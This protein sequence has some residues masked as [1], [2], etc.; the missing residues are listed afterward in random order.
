MKTV[1]FLKNPSLLVPVAIILTGLCLGL[2]IARAQTCNKIKMGDNI[3]ACW[4]EWRNELP[5]SLTESQTEC[6]GVGSETLPIPDPES[7]YYKDCSET[8]GDMFDHCVEDEEPV[9]CLQKYNCVWDPTLQT[10]HKCTTGA[11]VEPI[12]YWMQ[13]HATSP[14]CV[15]GES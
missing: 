6:S 10:P 7:V 1:A 3:N 15:P 5:C 2:G 14:S 4:A 8:V 13:T 9:N 11:A 12:A